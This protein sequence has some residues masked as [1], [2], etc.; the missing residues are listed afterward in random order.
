MT[1]TV[2]VPRELAHGPDHAPNGVA[3]GHATEPGRMGMV[4]SAPPC[5]NLRR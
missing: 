4:P 5:T 2:Q 3:R 1:W